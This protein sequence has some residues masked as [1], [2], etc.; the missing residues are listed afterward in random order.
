MFASRR[1]AATPMKGSRVERL[2]ASTP[3]DGTP[4][5]AITVLDGVFS[6][7]ECAQLVGRARDEIGFVPSKHKGKEDSGFRKSSRALFTDAALAR[8]LFSRVVQRLPNKI[9]PDSMA[10]TRVSAAHLGM[11]RSWGPPCGLWEELRVL[12]YHSGD[13]FRPHW[14]NRCT[15]GQSTE[16]PEAA[17]FLTLLLYLTTA[18]ADADA[19]SGATRVSCPPLDASASELFGQ[20]ESGAPQMGHVR[21]S[22]I[23]EV[24]PV[25]G[26]VLIFPHRLIHE[27]APVAG[28]ATKHVMRADVLYA[29]PRAAPPGDEADGEDGEE[30]S[31]DEEMDWRR[32]RRR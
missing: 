12:E 32:R 27:G 29:P 25:A 13:F 15:V 7:E 20:Y 2:D 26:R 28:T 31:D 16:F 22:A 18:D 21:D 5:S 6:A 17:S 1:E 11:E 19:A 8:E 23:A 14:D 9:R 30:E 10:I 24:L 4:L 3:T